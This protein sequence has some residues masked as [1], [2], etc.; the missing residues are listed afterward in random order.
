MFSVASVLDTLIRIAIWGGLLV[1][2][3]VCFYELVISLR[4]ARL[5][6]NLL[7]WWVDSRRSFVRQ[8]VHPPARQPGRDPL[9]T[10]GTRPSTPRENRIVNTLTE[11]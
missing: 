9:S 6:R 8:E 2:F 7:D 10:N 5:E 3:V 11:R 4:Q 1:L